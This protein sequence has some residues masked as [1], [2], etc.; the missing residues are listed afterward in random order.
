MRRVD[1]I[2]I[3]DLGTVI[4]FVAFEL[5]EV[6]AEGKTDD[7]W[8]IV[9]RDRE[10]KCPGLKRTKSKEHPMIA[11]TKGI[12]LTNSGK[13]YGSTYDSTTA[14]ATRACLFAEEQTRA[15]DAAAAVSSQ[16]Y[17]T[18]PATKKVG[19]KKVSQVLMP[20]RRNICLLEQDQR[21]RTAVSRK[22]NP[23]VQLL[24]LSH[25]ESQLVERRNR[26]RR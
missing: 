21:S 11:R 4:Y 1:S 6:Q 8:N 13:H 3:V 18:P 5:D 26:S 12:T 17:N 2:I 7:G 20:S 24:V 25:Q 19:A 16:V 22:S 9:N 14:T 10:K 23:Q 15:K